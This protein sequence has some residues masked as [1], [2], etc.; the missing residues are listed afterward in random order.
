MKYYPESFEG[1]LIDIGCG[2]GFYTLNMLSTFKNLHITG[3]DPSEKMMKE[4]RK[5]GV[6]GVL[7]TLEKVAGESIEFFDILLVCGVMEFVDDIDHFA[8]SLKILS[9]NESTLFVIVPRLNVLSLGYFFHHKVK[10]KIHPRFVE[11]Y[12]KA[13]EANGFKVAERLSLTAVSELLVV[14]VEKN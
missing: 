3:V 7:S 11:D 5:I 4:Y 13:L 14:K 6:R 9:R 8:K 12:A 2:P 10:N 1:K